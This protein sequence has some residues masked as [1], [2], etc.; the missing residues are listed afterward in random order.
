MAKL[1]DQLGRFDGRSR[2]VVTNPMEHA[3][4]VAGR[5]DGASM[6][7]ASWFDVEMLKGLGMIV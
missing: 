7:G 1:P 3:L 4:E 2:L 6:R 5:R